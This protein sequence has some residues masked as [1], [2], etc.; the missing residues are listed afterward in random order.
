MMK[1]KLIKSE[2][3]YEAAL[4][5]VDTLMSASPGSPE[6]DELE[7]WVHIVEAYEDANHPIDLPDPVDAIRFRME[8]QGLKPTDLVPYIGNKSKVSEVLGGKRKLSLAMIR[9][10]HKG[11]GIPADVLLGAPD[12]CLPSTYEDMDWRKYPLAEM[13]KRGWF[14]DA[15]RSLPDLRDRAEE[16]LGPFLAPIFDA[17]PKAVHLRQQV[18]KGSKVNEQALWAWKAR[19]WQLAQR[20]KIGTF[21][22][23]AMTKQFIGEVAKLS[24]LSEGPTV[25]ANILAKAGICLVTELQMPGTHLDGAAMRIGGKPPIIALTLRH[26]RIDNFWFTLCH[27]L[28]H[29]VLHLQYEENTSFLDDLDADNNSKKE[30][31]ADREAAQAMIPENEWKK[32]RKSAAP[33]KDDIIDFAAQNRVHPAIVAGRYRKETRN[34]KIFSD[35]IGNRKVRAMFR[36]EGE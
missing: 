6:A 9:N 20:Q 19:V 10:L 21:S 15:V 18:R 1:P 36:R 17:E 14:G 31:E 8:Q 24:T 16:I 12:S 26:D 2:A 13:V 22:S 28:A 33:S 34:Y 35:M 23:K 30:K 25:A 5:H 27:E 3:E 29:V 32:W 11:L 7:L 4:A